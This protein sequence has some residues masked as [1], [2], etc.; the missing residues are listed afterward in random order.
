MTDG[1][2]IKQPYADEIINGVKTVEYRSK[3]L[4]DD[5]RFIDVYILSGGYILGTASFDSCER[6][7]DGGYEWHIRRVSKLP[8]PIKYIHPKGA[9]VWI[10]GVVSPN[11]LQ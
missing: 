6:L 10:R 1:L 4:P 7:E 9:R 8:K 5:K 3:P 2:L 11:V